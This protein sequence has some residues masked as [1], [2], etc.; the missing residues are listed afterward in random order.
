[1]F[2]AR[3][4]L[5]LYVIQIMCFKRISEETAIISLYSVNWPVFIIETECVYCAVRTE[6]E[7][8]LY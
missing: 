7:I 6:V 5:S 8:Y 1:M 2:T 3:Y 4:G